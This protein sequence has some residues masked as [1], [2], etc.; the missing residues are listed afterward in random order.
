MSN[1]HFELISVA[2]Y[3]RDRTA[4]D[5]A[6]AVKDGD[7][8]A[9]RKMAYQMLPFISHETVLIPVPSRHGIATHTKSIANILASKVGGK[10][11]DVVVG[12]ERQS[13]YEVKYK[14]QPIAQDFFSFRLI[15]RV[16]P[17]I[18]VILD[19]VVDTGTTVCAMKM[20]VPN[21]IV[22]THSRVNHY[23]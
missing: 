19:T 10:V 22:L 13:I 21:A 3:Y 9:I 20:L 8:D 14:R 11:S 23:A 15:D 5:L 18:P 7:A 16:A 1:Y 12:R 17:G 2:D 6:H 4:R